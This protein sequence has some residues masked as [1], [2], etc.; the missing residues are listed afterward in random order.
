MSTKRFAIP[1]SPLRRGWARGPE[2]ARIVEA[3]S[4]SETDYSAAHGV[5][6]SIYFIGDATGGNTLKIGWSRDPVTRLGQLQIGNPTP[7]KCFGCVAAN[8]MIEPAL[9]MLFAAASVSGE[10]F[11]DPEGSIIRWLHEM[12]FDQP[13]ERC[14]WSMAGTQSVTWDWDEKTLRHR[15]L[16]SGVL[17]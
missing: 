11:T 15:P 6:G 16:L 1:S 3:R 10:W 14:H 5:V 13:I 4:L 17:E 7:L 12:T 8:R 2:H 9:H